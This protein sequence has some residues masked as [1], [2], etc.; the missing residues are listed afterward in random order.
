M[1]EVWIDGSCYPVNPGGTACV[2]Y[3]IKKGEITVAKGSKII[4]RGKGITNTVAEYNAFIC[5]L[6]EIKRRQLDSE[7]ILIRSNSKLLLDHMRG[8]WNVK[9]ES[10]FPL[11]REARQLTTNLK[12][13]IKWIS[14]ELNKEVNELSRLAFKN[15]NDANILQQSTQLEKRS[16]RDLCTF[17]SFLSDNEVKKESS[18]IE[19]SEKVL[20]KYNQIER[21]GETENFF[22]DY[23]KSTD[24]F[25]LYGKE[26]SE[27]CVFKLGLK[28][29]EFVK[30][31][32]VFQKRIKKLG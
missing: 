18:Q 22:I 3:V 31:F 23:D 24:L 16:E 17:P 2:G 4:G 11:Y 5:A 12:F 28:K 21:I 9:T 8:S 30:V 29:D 19:Q 13:N 26:I 14:R 10:V 20:K 7:E 6:K 32:E 27:N 25:L 15:C 1:I